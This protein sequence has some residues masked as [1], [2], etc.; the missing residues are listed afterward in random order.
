[1]SNLQESL[2]QLGRYTGKSV[3]TCKL[4]NKM[5]VEPG[6][7]G[8]KRIE[9]GCTFPFYHNFGWRRKEKTLKNK[10]S[11]LKSEE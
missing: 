6:N 1:M 9:L 11:H 3:N 4:Q 5:M 7:G 2:K 10:N 8:V